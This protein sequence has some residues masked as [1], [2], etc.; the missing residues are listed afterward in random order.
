MA[1]K[2]TE[3]KKEI[4]GYKNGAIAGGVVGFLYTAYFRKNIVLGILIG[5]VAGGYIGNMFTQQTTTT[6]FK[7][8]EF[9][10]P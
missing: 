3:K 1:K 9:K 8:T 6:E 4:D 10:K 7:K 5:V 2:N